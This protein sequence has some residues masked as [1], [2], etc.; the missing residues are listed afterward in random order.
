MTVLATIAERAFMKTLEG[1]CSVPVGVH[2]KVCRSA[3]SFLKT[4]PRCWTM[5]WSYRE[6]SGVWT[7]KPL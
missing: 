6:E 7:G 3:H 5:V 2:T 4:S 1:G